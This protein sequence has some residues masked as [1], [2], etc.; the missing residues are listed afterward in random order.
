MSAISEYGERNRGNIQ[1]KAY[2]DLLLTDLFPEESIEYKKKFADILRNVL[3]K[4]KSLRKVG[5]EVKEKFKLKIA[6]KYFEK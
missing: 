2:L 3:I 5:L 4:Y 6:L 1:I